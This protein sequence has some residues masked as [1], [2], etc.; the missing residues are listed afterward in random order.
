MFHFRSIS[1]T[2]LALLRT[3]AYQSLSAPL[4]GMWDDII[5]RSAI[6]GIFYQ[7][8]C[9]GYFS[10]DASY[11]LIYFYVTDPWLNRK[12][13]VLR[14]LLQDEY[15][16]QA[17]VGT[18]HPCFLNAALL[19]SYGASV[20][21]YLFEDQPDAQQMFSLPEAYQKA[22]FQLSGVD[23]INAIVKFCLRT[24][25]ADKNWLADYTRYW[26][27]RRGIYCLVLDKKILGTCEL[28]KSEAQAGIADLGAIVSPRHRKKGLG[29]YLMLRGKALCYEQ[30][31]QP[32]C[33]CRYDN[34]GSR[35]MIEKAGFVNRHNL[36]KVKFK[37]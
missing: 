7:T 23:D 27:A 3:Q 16:P 33:S 13:E 12:R 19:L 28:R 31:L 18:N 11:T 5:H 1:E 4:D 15:M 10:Y 34:Q 14:T 24:S 35:R 37:I 36:L 17:Y 25:S 6:K 8:E 9:I 29:T 20:Y 32:I 26:V 30:G 2:R 22:T 21:Y